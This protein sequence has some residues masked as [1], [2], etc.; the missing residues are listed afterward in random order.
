[1]LANKIIRYVFVIKTKKRFQ[2]LQKNRFHFTKFHKKNI[3]S[4][5][6]IH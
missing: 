4:M 1:M 3:E 6:I 2:K 5:A